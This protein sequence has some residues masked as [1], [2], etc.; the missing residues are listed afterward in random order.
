MLAGGSTG[1]AGAWSKGRGGDTPFGVH[2]EGTLRRLLVWA[3]CCFSVFVLGHE[4]VSCEDVSNVLRI[5][6]LPTAIKTYLANSELTW[7]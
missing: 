1:Y 2:L 3:V 6:A 4:H 7:D 5:S